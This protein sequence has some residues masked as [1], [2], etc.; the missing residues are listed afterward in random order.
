MSVDAVS[1]VFNRQSIAGAVDNPVLNALLTTLYECG[2]KAALSTPGTPGEVLRAAVET[3]VECATEVQEPSTVYG[4]KFKRL[5][6]DL[7]AKARLSD[8]AAQK[9]RR[10]AAGAGRALAALEIGELAF[11][12]SDQIANAMVGPLAWSIRGDGRPQQLGAWTPTCSS[13]GEDSNRLYKN[14]ALQD[15]F[16][17][18]SRELWEF[19][20]WKSAA[21]AAAAPA[22]AC[23]VDYRMR[24]ADYL[25]GSWGDPKAAKVVADAIVQ[26]LAPETDLTWTGYHGAE[27]GQTLAVAAR[28]LGVRAGEECGWHAGNDDVFLEPSSY[29][30]QNQTAETVH[31]GI[32]SISGD[33]PKVRGPLGVH[34]GMSERELRKTLGPSGKRITDNTYGV[35][36]LG[37][38]RPGPNATSYVWAQIQDGLVVSAGIAKELRIAEGQAVLYEG[39]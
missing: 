8:G 19:D 18:K 23:S 6:S 2:G 17:D 37:Y 20:G 14:I 11:Y 34:L 10:V 13:T 32:I 7:I 21:K 16:V 9:A 27:L 36:L 22:R 25:P 3:I 30:Q 39:C 29:D 35:R 28:N 1:Y 38:V 26:G 33:N 24:L 31:V 4:A 15:Q 12:A 5:S